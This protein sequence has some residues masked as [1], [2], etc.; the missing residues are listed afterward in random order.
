MSLRTAARTV[1]VE[2]RL[3]YRMAKALDRGCIAL[4]VPEKTITADG[5]SF[6]VRRGTCDE[7]FVQNVVTAREYLQ[8]GLTI[9]PGDVVLDVGANIG[10]FTV[11]AASLGAT[12]IAVEP[13][14]DNLRLLRTNLSLNR[15]KAVIHA[16]AATGSGGTCTLH[17]AQAGGGFN[18]LNAGRFP[19]AYRDAI[20]VPALTI[21]E[22]LREFPRCT[23]VKLDCEG[24]EFEL[25]DTWPIDRTIDQL[26]M[27]YHT[28]DP[29]AVERLVTRCRDLGLHVRHQDI[30]PT[31]RGGHLFLT[32]DH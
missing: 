23:F 2:R 11:L 15:L 9:A 16:A 19:R 3:P 7:D 21:A 22:I 31:H 5:L 14:P 18:T 29:Q 13:D 24:A 26:A 8:H 10:T 20:T 27:E 30:F 28:S 6:R 17:R 25:L 32:R 4:G 1:L 12:V